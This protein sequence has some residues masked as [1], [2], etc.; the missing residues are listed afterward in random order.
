MEPKEKILI[1]S[2]AI[3]LDEIANRLSRNYSKEKII[4]ECHEIAKQLQDLVNNDMKSE[5]ESET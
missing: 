3:F 4:A 2:L 5:S 1:L